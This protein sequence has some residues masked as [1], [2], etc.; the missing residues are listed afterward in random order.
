VTQVDPAARSGDDA[1]RVIVDEGPTSADRTFGQRRPRSRVTP[2][3]RWRLIVLQVFVVAFTLTLLGRLVW[4]QADNSAA[5]AQEADSRVREIAI[6]APR[7]L[8]VDQA[9]RSLSTNRPTTDV[10]LDRGLLAAQPDQGAATIAAVAA[11]TGTPEEDIRARMISCAD[12]EPPATCFTG[13]PYEPV[14]VVLDTRLESVIDLVE[15]PQRY[16][17]VQVRTR[18]VR[19]YDYKSGANAAHLLG[20]L[21]SPTQTELES[22]E[23]LH[24][25][26]QVGRGGIEASYDQYLRGEDGIQR[27]AL[28][29][30]GLTGEILSESTPQPGSTV[31]STIDVQLQ[32]AVEQQLAAAVERARFAGYPADSAAGVVLDVTNGDVL[33]MASIPTYDRA[34]FSGGL[35]D[36]EYQQLTSGEQPLFDRVIQAQ[37]APASTFKVITAAAAANAGFDLDQYYPCPSTY[38]VGNT[39]F[40]NYES[41]AFP[42]MPVSEALVVSCNTVFYEFADK[43]YTADGGMFPETTPQEWLTTTAKGFGLGQPTGIDLPGEAPGRIVDRDRKL[44]DYAELSE[45]YC[46]R[47]QRGY[48]EEPDPELAALYQQYAAEYCVDGDKYRV[49]DA[50]N[51]SVG[52]GDSLLTPLQLASVYA[53]IANGGTIYQPRVVK[54]VVEQDGTVTEVNGQANGQ[55]PMSPETLDY[56]RNALRQ[57]PERGTASAAFAGFPLAE[58]PV[59]GK[60]GTAEVQNK[61]TTSLFASY[62]PADTPR[63]A[64]VVAITQ[65][66]VGGEQSAPAA[67]GIYD[68]IF[69]VADGQADPARS[70][71]VGGVPNPNIPT[72]PG[73]G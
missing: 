49:G 57:V 29:R 53:A 14:P 32:A 58:V 44:A 73:V 10:L 24:A 16:A 33:A 45:A 47:A 51:F 63:Y 36:A 38:Y 60:T 42:P 12:P 34:V 27:L 25:G 4:I 22:D 66:G 5:A 40:A 56:I 69:G 9:G 62:A 61:E 17:G 67:R 21:G 65:A 15:N 13:G 37:L 70:V 23:T 28:D 18:S 54:A 41:S 20:Y 46:D 35:T 8:I 59:A 11:V 68:A 1:V 50:I 7:G 2:R 43:M 31:V 64:V 71:L 30:T 39:G 52:Q 19:D 48:P 6:P 3:S 55:I 26:S 72:P